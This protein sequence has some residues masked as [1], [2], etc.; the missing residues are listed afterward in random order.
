RSRA[1]PVPGRENPD[2][3]RPVSAVTM[4]SQLMAGEAMAHVQGES[5]K[6]I[7]VVLGRLLNSPTT[8]APG[9]RSTEG[10]ASDGPALQ[11]RGGCAEQVSYV[12]SR[13]PGPLAHPGTCHP[14]RP[15]MDRD[16]D[17]RPARHSP[18]PSPLAR[19]PD[20]WRVPGR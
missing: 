18:H 8:R 20:P 11:R 19:P 12:A 6:V 10:V 16:A 3:R 9:G 7:A 15:R 2:P 13:D 4:P 14:G 5:L 17:P 1:H